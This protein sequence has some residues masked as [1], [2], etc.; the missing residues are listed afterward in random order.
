MLIWN[1]FTMVKVI[2]LYLR[3]K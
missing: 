1:N 3:K 2:I